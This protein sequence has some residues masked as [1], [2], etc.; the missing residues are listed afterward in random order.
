MIDSDYV[1]NK[2]ELNLMKKPRKISL[3]PVEIPLTNENQCENTGDKIIDV[4]IEENKGDEQV[5]SVVHDLESEL[6]LQNEVPPE[7]DKTELQMLLDQELDDLL[8]E[9]QQ[10]EQRIDS[11]NIRLTELGYK[12]E[13][14]NSNNKTDQCRQWI[15]LNPK[16]TRS[17]FMTQFKDLGSKAMLSTYWQKLKP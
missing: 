5:E 8:E 11:I 2:L 12:V 17:D 1:I 16:C 4:K 7:V 13:T 10:L 3:N 6:V 14:N 9:K 15:K